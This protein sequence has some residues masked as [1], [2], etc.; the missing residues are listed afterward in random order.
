MNIDISNYLI[1]HANGSGIRALNL[2]SV[3]LQFQDSLNEIIYRL[4]LYVGLY[5]SSVMIFSRPMP[6]CAEGTKRH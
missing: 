5:F 1:I 4:K 3:W 6:S 2:V